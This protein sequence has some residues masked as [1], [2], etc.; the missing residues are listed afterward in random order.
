M[1]AGLL[2]LL[3]DVAALA[4]VAAASLDDITTQAVTSSSK[5]MGIVIDD[6]AVT[7]GFIQG[8]A[9]KRELPVVARIALGSLRNKLLVLLPAAL[10][11]GYFAPWVI[12]PL[13]MLGGCYLGYEAAEKIVHALS[14]Q[15]E[16][17]PAAVA[18]EEVRVRSA[19][20]T[21]FILSA[22]IMA[23]TLGTVSKSATTVQVAVLA[24]VGAGL[25]IAVYAV[26]ALIVKAD[27]FGLY[28]ARSGTAPV[29]AIGRALVVGVPK[30]LQILS[31]VGTAAMAWVAGGILLHG[32]EELGWAWPAET[33]HHLAEA[34]GPA[35]WF[36]TT[37]LSG[38]LGVAVGAALLPVGWAVSAIRRS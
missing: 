34:A 28:L 22:E 25:T 6:A 19:V 15:D 5:A 30:V 33:V 20:Q 21:D 7:P 36:V 31:V 10:L 9:A 2:G 8:T 12:T 14:A 38:V 26:V 37:G 4:K 1:S 11:L 17:G 3:D 27:D 23:I 29:R 24:G 32:M 35:A 18:S 16:H 13:L